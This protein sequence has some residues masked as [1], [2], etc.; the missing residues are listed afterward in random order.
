MKKIIM[1]F[2]LATIILNV[3]LNAQKASETKDSS[4]IIGTNIAY[5]FIAEIG[6]LYFPPSISYTGVFINSVSFKGTNLVGLGVGFEFTL[7]STIAAPLF[8]NYRH[9][10]QRRNS[11]VKPMVN[12]A[13]GTRFEMAKVQS[14]L[15][16]YGHPDAWGGWYR[17]ADSQKD[18]N[19]WSAGLYVTIEGGFTYKHFTLA[20]GFHLRSGYHGISGGPEIKIG[21][22]L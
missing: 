10:F 8:I 7:N 20:G 18:T 21:F 14:T 17:E 13:A 16:Y 6:F 3:N 11:N 9:H 2:I 5:S 19:I 22:N 4:K 15:H 12:I 1:L